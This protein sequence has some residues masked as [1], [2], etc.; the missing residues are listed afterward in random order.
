MTLLGAGLDE[1]VICE[2]PE[3]DGIGMVEML[4]R[5]K[6]LMEAFSFFR[7]FRMARSLNSIQT[8]KMLIS[9]VGITFIM[10]CKNDIDFK[11]IFT[12]FEAS[13]PILVANDTYH[14][15]T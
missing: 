3:S 10:N 2:A 9:T 1:D 5:S 8:F 15:E 11:D 13:T 7:C 6:L 4:L 12:I 14:R